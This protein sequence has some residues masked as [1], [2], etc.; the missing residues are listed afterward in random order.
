MENGQAPLAWRFD[1]FTLDLARDP[2]DVR[3]RG[4]NAVGVDLELC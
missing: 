1:R 4:V 2:G 3:R